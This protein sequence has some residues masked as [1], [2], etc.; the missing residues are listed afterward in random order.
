MVNMKSIKKLA[1]AAGAISSKVSDKRLLE[2][3]KCSEKK[4]YINSSRAARDLA[5]LIRTKKK[6]YR[7]K[8]LH[9]YQC[10]VCSCYHIGKKK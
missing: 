8:T 10:G 9:V 4:L 3:I 7:N 6:K 5:A 1:K 2:F